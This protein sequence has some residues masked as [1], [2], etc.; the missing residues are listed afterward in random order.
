MHFVQIEKKWQQIWRQDNAFVASE[1]FTKQKYYV[2]EMF[3]YPSGKFHV[4]HLRNYSIGDV[5]ARYFRANGYNVLH[6]MGWDAFGLPA[7]NAAITNQ[8]HPS[9]WT[10]SNVE[11]MRDQLI[12]IGLSYDWSKEVTSCSPDYYKHEQQ[13]FLDLHKKG[14]A[15]QKE[16]LVNW[17]PIDNTVLANE[18]VVEG[19]GW[20][21]GALVEKKHL[22]QW[23][24]RITDYADE[25]LNDIDTLTEWPDNVRTMQKNWIGKSEGVRFGFD[26]HNTT[27][28]IEVYSTKPEVLFGATF[29]AIAYNHPIVKQITKNSDITGFI[30]KCAST[31]TSETAIEKAHKECVPTGL[32]A[33]HPF[34]NKQ[35]PII[36]ANFVLM[37]YG[38]G[39]VYGCPAHDQRDFE[40]VKNTPS[41]ELIQT[42]K[43]KD[44][45]QINL[46]SEAYIYHE[47]DVM[48]NSDFLNNKSV[49]E[50]RE[51]IINKIEDIGIGQREINFRLKDWG[52]SRQR[53]WGCP[54][55][56]IYCNSCG[57]VPVPANDLPIELPYDVNFTQTG[58]PLHNHPTWKHVNC[59]TC[60][61]PSLRETDTFDTF[62]ESSWYFTRFCNNTTN[63]MVDKKACKYWLPVD[64][65]IGGIEHAILHLL[66]ARFFTKVMSDVGYLDIR[67]PFKRLLTQGMV[68]HAT[69]KDQYGKWISPQDIIEKNNKY[70]HNSTGEEVYKG[71][72]EKM[73]KSKLNT[74]DLEQMLTT[75]GADSL[76]MFV[77]SD[78]PVEKDLEWSASGLAGCKKFI[79]KLENFIDKLLTLEHTSFTSEKLQIQI[80]STIQNVSDD[81]KSYRLNKAIARIRE[82]FNAAN[83]ELNKTNYD[84]KSI[85]ESARI[86]IQLLNP[87]IP[88]ITE[89]LWHKLGNDT[90][91]YK[92]SWPQADKSK[93]TSDCYIMAIQI[94]GKL[95]ATHEFSNSNSDDEIKNTALSLPAITT[96]I[97]PEEIKKVIIIP[98]KIINIVK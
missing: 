31:S 56:I 83:D 52:V 96:H 95:R 50:A 12:D 16:S 21:S 34:N 8:S 46:D 13:F 43:N 49:L 19:R 81:I 84:K 45:Q 26:I 65:Y 38:T 14:L 47:H 15:Y 68:L 58:N 27:E 86:I 54:I 98:K 41:L 93:L 92:S 88:H 35:I 10:Y 53:Y 71:K 44:N 74:I 4:G 91:L 29:I 90:P 22:K 77:L 62:F 51:L 24:L 76:R 89:E 64:Q 5:I 75:H 18:Q 39:A 7:E 30:K 1:D 70:F 61:A 25:L 36:I 2:L 94:N 33:I 63:K 78:S 55:P 69:Y 82:L 23:F 17:D 80:H 28:K 6:P 85:T 87:F 20:R 42:V 97:K 3:P 9:D 72:I 73:S 67:E 59:P 11:I 32:Y 57:T 60:N 48:I 66:Y 79:N 40:L 37:D